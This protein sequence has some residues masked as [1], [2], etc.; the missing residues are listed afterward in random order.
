MKLGVFVMA[1]AHHIWIQLENV[2]RRTTSLSSRLS[3]VFE[4]LVCCSLI[5]K[6]H[7]SS[8]KLFFMYSTDNMNT[9]WINQRSKNFKEHLHYW[10]KY[11]Y[12]Y[13]IQIYK[14]KRKR[15]LEKKADTKS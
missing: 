9:K 1:E 5:L 11:M 6:R 14:W 3:I 4:E 15:Y 10:K 8:S 12:M 13:L 7:K 2:D